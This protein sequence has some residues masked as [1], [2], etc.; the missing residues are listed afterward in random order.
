M[1][2][3]SAF[4]HWFTAA[5]KAIL[6]FLMSAMTVLVFGNVVGRYGF[7]VSFGWADELSR[8]AMIWTAFLGVGLALRYG[9]LA[10]VEVVQLMLPESG[11]RAMRIS[12]AAVMAAF[13]VALVILGTQF[14]LFSWN[15]RTPV[16]Q[17]PRGIPYLAVPIGAAL[18]LIHL[19]LSLSHFL[20][21]EDAAL[22]GFDPNAIELPG[23]EA[24]GAE[25]S[26]PSGRRS[27]AGDA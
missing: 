4:D 11:A 3:G 21:G 23:D 1:A 17:I 22:D 14:T 20:S 27:P 25:V 13:L 26:K 15:L 9:Q 19:T 7:G 2:E 18:G 12:V 24:G 8:F 16:L 10:A 5:N 6:V